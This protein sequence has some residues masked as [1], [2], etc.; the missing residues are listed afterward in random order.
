[1]GVDVFYIWTGAAVAYYPVIF[2][3]QHYLKD[4][5]PFDLG[6]ASTKCAVNWI[7]WWETALAVFS[8]IGAYYVLPSALQPFLDG[9]SW[10]QAICGR[11]DAL[12][13]PS[14]GYW[15]FI[16]AVSKLVE[17]GDTLFVVLRKKKLIF[18]QHYHHLATMMYTWACCFFVK[19]SHNSNNIYF[20]AMNYCVHSVMYTWYAATRTGWR[21][22]K[23][24]MMFVTLLQML[25]MV[26]GLSLILT[27]AQNGCPDPMV[28]YG[29]FM[30]FSY[31]ALFA[32]I[33]YSNY[34]VKKSKKKLKK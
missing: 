10:V 8:I 1:M 12:D 28:N 13:D 16:F 11:A 9:K 18:L 17:F 6:G 22:P 27:S 2:G 5:E 33:F 29:L 23:S 14:S 3:I 15:A 20:C 34:V 24:L 31:L 19:A 21:S 26:G 4:A 7:F 32:Q 30:Y 25:Q